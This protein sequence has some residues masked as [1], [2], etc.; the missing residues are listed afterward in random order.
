[1]IEER[2]ERV[3]EAGHPVLHISGDDGEAD[4]HDM[5]R[6]FFS[7]PLRKASMLT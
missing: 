2:R 4:F 6:L 5:T 1:L 3:E 7:S